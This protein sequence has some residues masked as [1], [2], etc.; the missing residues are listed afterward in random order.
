MMGGTSVFL[1][2]H[3]LGDVARLDGKRFGSFEPPTLEKRRQLQLFLRL[4]VGL[5]DGLKQEEQRL[6]DHF[7]DGLV[8]IS[9]LDRPPAFLPIP[10]DVADRQAT[11]APGKTSDGGSMSDRIPIGQDVVR[12]ISEV[13]DVSPQSRPGLVGDSSGQASKL[14]NALGCRHAIGLGFSPRSR[15]FAELPEHDLDVVLE[16]CASE[17]QRSYALKRKP[18]P[19]KSGAQL[20]SS[21]FVRRITHSSRFSMW[22]HPPARAA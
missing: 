8:E 16:R 14:R 12:R 20:V 2:V 17:D 5:A 10:W 15:P 18:K 22:P 11:S 3:E 4:P 21:R 1:V 9:A 6:Q 7:E 19:R 13:I